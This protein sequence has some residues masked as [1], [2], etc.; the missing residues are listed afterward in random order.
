MSPSELNF[1][2]STQYFRKCT[3]SEIAKFSTY[4]TPK[5]VTVGTHLFTQGE[6]ET[7]WFLVREGLITMKRRTMSG[8][9]HVLAELMPGEAFG[10]MGL[11][12]STPRMASAVAVTNSIVLKLEGQTFNQ[13]LENN[14]RVA[15]QMLRAMAIT[16]SQRLREM[17][18][19][20]QDL[21]DMD[22]LGEY[23]PLPNPLDMH[24]FVGMNPLR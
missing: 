3:L 17:T 7:G 1:L 24:S 8:M 18:M 12:E 19:I 9:D 23:A 13:L 4:L 16:Q 20:M 11:L 2:V 21:T 10:E 22:S 5:K 15:C 6:V 14:D